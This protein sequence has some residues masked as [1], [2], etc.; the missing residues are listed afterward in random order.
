MLA[1]G[2]GIWPSMSNIRCTFTTFSWK[3]GSDKISSLQGQ[4]A[5]SGWAATDVLDT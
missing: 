5:K 4:G 3:D 1:D 2:V